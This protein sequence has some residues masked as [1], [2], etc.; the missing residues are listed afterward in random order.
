MQPETQTAI[1]SR[2]HHPVESFTVFRQANFRWF[3]LGTILANCATWTQDVTL[4]WLVYDLTASGAMLGTMSLVRTLATLGLSPMAGI[5]IDRRSRRS[6]MFLTNSWFLVINA[7]IGLSLLAGITQ[8]WPLLLFSLLTGIAQAIDVPLRQTVLFALVPRRLTPSALGINQTGWAVMRTLGPAIGA[9]LLVRMGAGGSFL[10][11]AAIYAI[12]LM[13][14]IQLHFPQQHSAEPGT[15]VSSS[16]AE[17]FKH[18]V[19]N[20]NTRAFAFMGCIL[21]LF[22]IPVFTVMPAI[23]AKDLFQGGPQVLGWLLSAIG[24]GGVLGGF[25]ATSLIKTDCRGRVELGAMLLLGLSLVGF[26]FSTQLWVALVFLGLAGFFEMI[27][28][29]TNQTLLQLSIPDEL[30]GRVNGIITLSSGLMP[31]GSLIAGIG[32]DTIG[33][34]PTGALLGGSAAAIT[35]IVFLASP[36][37]R[38]YRLSRVLASEGAS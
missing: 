27:F 16:F 29:I 13:I 36:T 5:A 38:R 25:V 35:A 9:F 26:A 11:Q 23:F 37:I 6:L 32:A 3:F 28:L 31:L 15:A 22:T 21:R 2:R 7:G 1:P 17:G 4:S 33:P 34:R 12:I 24:L 20:A 10:I 19:K 14:I 18:I 30:R 8:V